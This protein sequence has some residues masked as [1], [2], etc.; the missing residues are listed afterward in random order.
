M[1][2]VQLFQ[3]S[4]LTKNQFI[5]TLSTIQKKVYN[6]KHIKLTG[7]HATWGKNN[8]MWSMIY[9]SFITKKK[10]ANLRDGGSG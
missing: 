6:Y 3:D 4:N 9:D 5:S 8:I 10:E 1:H 2:F 7:S